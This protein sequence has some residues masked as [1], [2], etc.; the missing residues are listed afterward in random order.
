MK[1]SKGEK[2]FGVCNHAFMIL[3]CIV[4]IYP[5]WY[6]FIASFSDPVAV[7]TGQV[8]LWPKGFELASYKKVM[9][10]GTIFKAYA[11]TIFYS[12][13]GSVLS[14]VLTTLTAYA[15][16]KQ[17]LRGRRIINFIIMM[18]MWFT[19]GMMPTFLNFRDLGLY[20]TRLGVLLH[21]AVGAFYVIVLR[22]FF[23]GVPVSLEESAKLDG[24]GELRILF[25]IY[26]PL[27][28]P[29]MASIMLYYFVG[30]WNGYFWSML[31][32][33]DQN[34]IPL[35]V[36]L[37]RLIVEVSYSAEEQSDFSAFSMTE[38]T[39]VYATVVLAVIPMIVMY[40]FVQ[41]FFVKGITVGAVKG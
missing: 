25:N 36:I 41:K 37:K 15:L 14:M 18:P 17:R 29:S 40:P 6:V 9:E 10:D 27:S 11:N 35:Q 39:M 16:S 19:A 13:V 32:L 8:L 1:R 2:I 22:T 20:D 26:V 30:R 4:C 33:K 21:G 12:V 23:E 31:L 5:L 7:S 38:Q 28:V 3:L 24:A 34:K